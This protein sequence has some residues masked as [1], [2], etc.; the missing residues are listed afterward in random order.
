MH[1]H[2]K[3]LWLDKSGGKSVYKGDFQANVFHGIGR[4]AWANGDV[5]EG[6]FE[7]G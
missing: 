4:L 5:Y 3:L 1:G 6:C 2:G 7:N